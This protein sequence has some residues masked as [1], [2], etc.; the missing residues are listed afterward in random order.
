MLAATRGHADAVAWLVEHGA[1]LDRSAKSGLSATM[2]AVLNGH[3]DVVDTLAHV[4]AR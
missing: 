1:K 4:T 2:L 3:S